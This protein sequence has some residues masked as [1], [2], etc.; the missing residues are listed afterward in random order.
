MDEESLKKKFKEHALANGFRLNS[1]E[2]FLDFILKSFIRNKE[3][4]GEFYCPCRVLTG[5]EEDEKIICPCVFHKKEIEDAGHCH[6]F[7]FFK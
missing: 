5:T 3:Q 1:D 6:C 2:K 4:K 7:L